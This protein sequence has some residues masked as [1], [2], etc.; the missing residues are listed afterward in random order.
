MEQIL[1]VCIVMN[2]VALLG[3]VLYKMNS[4]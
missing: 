4:K 1:D 2:V 3:T